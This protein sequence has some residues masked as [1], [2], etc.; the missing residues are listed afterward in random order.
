MFRPTFVDHLVFRVSDVDRTSRFYSALLGE[1]YRADEY[2][3]YS[4]GNTLLFFTPSVG[5]AQ[6][7]DKEKVGLNHIAMGVRTVDE[8]RMVESQL[9][10]ASIAHS[11]IKIWQDGVTRYIWLDD[12][13]GIRL[14]YWLRSP[15]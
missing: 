5:S 8:L 6:P 13:D 15:E 7:Y 9:N 12:P 1:P 10:D 4:A 11:G 3:M 14:E 2:V